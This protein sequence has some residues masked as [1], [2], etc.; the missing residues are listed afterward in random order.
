MF[1]HIPN[2]LLQRA[3]HPIERAK[4]PWRL[5][6]LAINRDAFVEALL[7]LKEYARAEDFPGSVISQRQ[8]TAAFAGQVARECER[9]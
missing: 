5:N 1:Q 6:D 3:M 4:C 2:E 8:I 9:R 7:T